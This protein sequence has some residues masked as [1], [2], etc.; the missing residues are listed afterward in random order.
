MI[1]E[2]CNALHRPAVLQPGEQAGG[3]SGDRDAQGF[4]CR[5][6]QACRCR[7]QSI[8]GIRISVNVA[9]SYL[10]FRF[11]VVIDEGLE[12]GAFVAARLRRSSLDDNRIFVQN[13]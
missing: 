1:R 7:F 13:M 8:E 9:H 6:G 11:C 3:S 4:D 12:R 10:P 5:Y 2:A